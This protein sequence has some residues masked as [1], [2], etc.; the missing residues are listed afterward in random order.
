MLLSMTGYGH[1]AVESDK[2]SMQVAVKSL[3]SKY[4]DYTFRLPSLLLDQE[5][6]LRSQ[7]EEGLIRGKVT[8]QVQLDNKQATVAHALETLQQQYRILRSN[9]EQVTESEADAGVRSAL[10]LHVLK[11]QKDRP[12]ETWEAADQQ[13]LLRGIQ[14]AVGHCVEMRAQEGAKTQTFIEEGVV[15]IERHIALITAYAPKQRAYI[16][17]KLQR[18][19]E[20]SL[21]KLDEGIINKIRFEEE[22]FY[23]IEKTSFNEELERLQTHVSFFKTQLKTA[24]TTQGKRLLFITQ[25]MVREMNTLGAKANDVEVQQWVVAM[26]TAAARIK[27]QLQNIL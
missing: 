15:E 16:T 7:I 5:T 12:S 3:N 18:G 26:K 11:Q 10:F 22:L 1:A 19:M 2:Y 17:E 24:E 9:Y 14:L 6:S 21:Q 4:M 8:I 25:E 20:R 27:E 23:Y 13:T